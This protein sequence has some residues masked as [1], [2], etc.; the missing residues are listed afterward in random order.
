MT[1]E[2]TRLKILAP[3]DTLPGPM[4]RTEPRRAIVVGASSGIGAALASSLARAGYDTALVARSQDKLADLC[5][6]IRSSG[7]PGVPH[8]YVHDVCAYGEVPALFERIVEDLHGLD[9]I[10]Y[11]AGVMPEVGPD[12]FDLDKD[13]SIVE[14]NLIGA[15]AWLNEAAR[16][17]SV[18]GRGSLVGIS[19]MAGERGRRAAPAYG[20]SKAGLNTYLE[21]LRNRLSVLGVHVLTVKPGFVRTA[22][23]DGRS[24]AFWVSEP[25]A[26]AAQILRAMERGRREIFVSPRWRLVSWIV[27][28]IPS[29]LFRRLGI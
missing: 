7:A 5:E 29:F 22:M 16:W 23:L 2:D 26:A 1:A 8:A 12:E 17:L 10:L 18:A 9:A 20:A 6:A 19:S 15:M 24:S 28:A 27:R 4:D 25:E 13:R 21:S 3:V 11:V 14:T